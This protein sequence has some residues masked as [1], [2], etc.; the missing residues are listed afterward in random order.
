M[1]SDGI[2]VIWDRQYYPGM[3][4]PPTDPSDAPPV[5]VDVVD[6]VATVTL[7]D[8]GNRNALS[9]AVV[10][11]L[12]DALGAANADPTVRVVVVTNT[13]G[14]FCA[15]AD[16]SEQSSASAAGSATGARGFDEVLR[17]IQASPTPVVGRI[18]GHAVAGGV[19]LAA[20]FDISIARDDVLLGFTEVRVGVIPA[21]ISVVCL[22]K[23]RRGDALEA[24]LRGRRFPATEAA[25][26]GLITRAVP[27]DQLDSAVAEVVDDLKRGGPTALALAK[28][29]VYEVPQLTP[30]EAFR[31]TSARSA[32]LFASDEA[33]EGMAAFLEKRRPSW[34][35]EEG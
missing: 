30:D 25:R 35:P 31:V 33:A 9:R 21:I 11:G 24:F 3:P 13:G 15:G 5:L 34:A 2:A 17:A 7:A 14:V 10:G 8:P 28:Q 1:A 26:L 20:V 29:L 19:G 6:G 32:A 27:A 22:P 16:L 23:M 18:D 12:L 4:P